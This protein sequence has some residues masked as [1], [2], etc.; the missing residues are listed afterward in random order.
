MESITCKSRNKLEI[1]H[2]ENHNSLRRF[3]LILLALIIISFHNDW[4]KKS[5]L[6]ISFY[7]TENYLHF[8]I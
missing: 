8:K 5:F 3:I 2:D 7:L 1:E 6:R 4:E